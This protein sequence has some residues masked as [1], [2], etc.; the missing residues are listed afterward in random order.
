MIPVGNTIIPPNPQQGM[1][2]LSDL[3]GLQQKR[4]ALQTGQYL[5]QTAAAE[6]SQEQRKNAE[7][8]A[9]AKFSANAIQDPTYRLPDGTLD[10][11][12]YQTGAMTV[13]P[14]YGA[15]VIGQQTSNVREAI[16][17]RSAIQSLSAAQNAQ[18]TDGLK[19]LANIPGGATRT[20]LLNWKEQLTANNKDPAFARAIDNAMISLQP[21]PNGGYSGGA[22][23]MAAS[24][25]GMSMQQPGQMDVG[26]TIQPG[27]TTTMGPQTGQFT[28]QG[29]AV[30]KTLAPTVVAGPGGV[31][32]VWGGGGAQ[33]PPK[34]PGNVQPTDVDYKNFGDYQNNLNTRVQV[35]T[36]AQARIAATEQALN[37]I[38]NKAGA[39]TRASIA[40]T[41]QALGAP[42]G[43]VDAVNEGDLGKTQEAEKFLF[44]TTLTGLRQAMQGDSAHVSEFNAANAVFPNIDTDPRAKAKV[45]GFISD[46]AERDYREQQAL[47]ESRKAGTFNPATWQ[48]DYQQQLRAGRIP[49]TPESQIPRPS[50]GATSSNKTIKRTGTYKGR[51]VAEY[52]DG[53]HGYID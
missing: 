45:M 24:L 22:A 7:L 17:I 4:Q 8:Q 11:Q 5:Q 21:D 25:G 47:N 13:A 31:P 20:D 49:G 26:G 2:T 44:Q 38:R 6:A 14:T 19:G 18:I 48:G 1:Q 41:L 51:K 28:P 40:K 29:S 33:G 12:K 27:T 16:G 36:D 9:L 30:K 42:D 23:K 50:Q 34:A 43:L 52:S 46:Q 37:A 3:L 35:G 39:G 10:V 15:P 53:T 32:G